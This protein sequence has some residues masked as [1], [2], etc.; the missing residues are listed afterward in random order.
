[1]K[2]LPGI[3]F[4]ATFLLTFLCLKPVASFA[5]DFKVNTTKDELDFTKCKP[6]TPTN[7]SLRAAILWSNQLVGT[8]TITLPAGVFP[9]TRL[10]KEPKVNPE[11]FND[12]NITD[13]VVIKGAGIDKTII[14]G[15][16]KYRAFELMDVPDVAQTVFFE[17]LTIR[18]AELNPENGETFGAGINAFCMHFDGKDNSRDNLILRHVRMHHNILEGESTSFAGLCFKGAGLW[19]EDSE[20]D[21]HEHH[22]PRGHDAAGGIM[23]IFGAD[24]VVIK[25]SRIHDN[26]DEDGVAG[27]MVFFER[28]RNAWMDQ[29]EISN[30]DG[31]TQVCISPNEDGTLLF[32]NTTFS[33]NAGDVI[34]NS[35]NLGLLHVTMVNNNLKGLSDRAIWNAGIGQLWLKNTIIANNKNAINCD[36]DTDKKVFSL[37]NNI[38][39]DD[40]CVLSQA[41]DHADTDPL[42]EP[43]QFNGGPSRSHM[44]KPN[45]I[46]IDGGE[47]LAEVTVDQRG[48]KRPVGKFS[49]IGAVERGPIFSIVP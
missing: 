32:S 31:E 29:S 25:R 21:H 12:F 28:V 26:Q 45:S 5:V 23:T 37:G 47:N 2:K 34:S 13:S 11:T 38:A 10:G 44:P 16:N 39:S 49:D 41:S 3:L 20:F 8:D 48:M 35:A 24:S 36:P 40:T 33:G 6:E 19:I 18:N 1:M 42:L 9:I 14:D 7:C 43:L 22:T 27:C 30:N 15:M 17:G 46:A 4:N